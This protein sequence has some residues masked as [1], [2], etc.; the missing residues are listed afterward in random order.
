MTATQTA[1]P[2]PSAKPVAAPAKPAPAKPVVKAG[3]K[4]AVKAAPKAAPAPAA[5]PAE[6]KA[7]PLPAKSAP[8]TKTN[9]SV[10]VA[11]ALG[12]R[13]DYA[14]IKA[15]FSAKALFILGPQSFGLISGWDNEGTSP[16]LFTQVA[17]GGNPCRAKDLKAKVG[18]MVGIRGDML[19]SAAHLKAGDLVYVD[20]TPAD[21]ETNDPEDQPGW[22]AARIVKIGVKG[23]TVTFANVPEAGEFRYGWDDVVA[24][25]AEIA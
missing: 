10:N 1:R 22:Y 13:Y 3:A 17:K 14:E 21:P 4:P 20:Y 9:A 23:L 6:G 7:K 18:A 25:P 24:V 15:A 5:K 12:K 16:L 8:A 11:G 19:E 2:K